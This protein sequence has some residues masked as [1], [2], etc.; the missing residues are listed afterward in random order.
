[1]RKSYKIHGIYLCMTL[2]ALTI[3][4]LAGYE[5]AMN[6]HFSDDSEVFLDGYKL[7]LPEEFP[8]CNFM[9]NNGEA[10]QTTTLLYTVKSEQT[11]TI[12]IL[13]HGETK[14]PAEFVNPPEEQYKPTSFSFR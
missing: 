10:V 5:H 14:T 4:Y 9:I 2:I 8:V 11:K 1:M 6:T 3:G 12:Y 13:F 7:E